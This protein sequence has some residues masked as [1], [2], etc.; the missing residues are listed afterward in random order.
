MFG[1]LLLKHISKFS[2][3]IEMTQEVP[4]WCQRVFDTWMRQKVEV[5]VQHRF[6]RV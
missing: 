1:D 3:F 5:V 6:H 4:N 2:K